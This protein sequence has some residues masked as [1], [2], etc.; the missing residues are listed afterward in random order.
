V[1]SEVVCVCGAEVPESAGP[2]HAY[3]PAVAGCWQAFGEVQA[4]ELTRFRYPDAHGW[5]VDAYMASHPGPGVDPRDS[6][7]VVMHLLAL[8]ARIERGMGSAAVR[9]LVLSPGR[10]AADVPVLVR[11]S[12][13]SP[14]T[15]LSMIGAVDL[16][17]YECRARA[18]GAEV[19]ASW[20]HERD[21]LVSLW[22]PPA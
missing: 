8:H 6:R 14:I 17:D 12:S 3:V 7:S 5:V 2:V 16:A 10:V 19:W 1:V 18:W 13:P 21:R 22:T 4:D 20:A 15:I 9:R 11:P